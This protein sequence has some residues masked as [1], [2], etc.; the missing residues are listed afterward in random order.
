MTMLSV[1]WLFCLVACLIL[2]IRLRFCGY[3]YSRNDYRKMNYIDLTGVQSRS[4]NPGVWSWL[5]SN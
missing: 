4:S 1:P 5:K 2:W 3:C